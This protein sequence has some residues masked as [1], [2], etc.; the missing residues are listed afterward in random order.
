MANYVAKYTC[1]SCAEY[2]Y[3]GE[4]RKGY[5]NKYR[6]YY[7]PDDSCNSWEEASDRLSSG[8]SSCFLTS[9]CCEYRN[10]PDNCY[11]LERL[12]QFRDT[13]IKKQEYGAELIKNYY[14]IAPE[15]I[16]AINQNPQK[17]DIYQNIWDKIHV[18]IQLID[19]DKP[20]VAII[21][22]MLMV[23]KLQKL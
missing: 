1:G 7:Y 21:E 8:S 19:Q 10:L 5:C 16:E 15:I 9:A 6:T 11:E 22:Y 14:D 12:R 20:D 13:Y 3:E 18:I 23:I 17:G 2:E 4:N